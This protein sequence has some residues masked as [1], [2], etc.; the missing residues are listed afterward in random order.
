MKTYVITLSKT[1]FSTHPR[2]GESTNFKEKFLSGEKIHTIRCNYE[3]WAKRIAEVQRGEAVLSIREWCGV[4]Y[5]SKQEVIRVLTKEDRVEIQHISMHKPN[6]DQIYWNINDR[7]DPYDLNIVSNNDGLLLN[8]F[9]RWFFPD[10]T[11]KDVIFEGA[12]IH[13]TKFRY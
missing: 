13:F 2:K 3:L 10:K 12:I 7:R 6:K 9:I 1:F 8:D 11:K 4:P 5:K